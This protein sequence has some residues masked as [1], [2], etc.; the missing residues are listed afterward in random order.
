MGR[1]VELPIKDGNPKVVKVKAKPEALQW[2]V[3]VSTAWGITIDCS[4]LVIMVGV[5]L[6]QRPEQLP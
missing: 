5:M 2:T 1:Y 3:V 4:G 6:K